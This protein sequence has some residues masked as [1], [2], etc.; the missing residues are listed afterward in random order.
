MIDPESGRPLPGTY[1]VGWAKRG[2]SGGIGAN[3]ACAQETVGA[4]LDDAAAGALSDP[5]GTRREL[6]RLVRSRRPDAVG[7]RHLRAID[8]AERALGAAAGRPRVKLA[9]LPALLAAGRR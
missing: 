2:P 9:T 4:L 8:R 6:A 5:A 7:L 3:R 1:V